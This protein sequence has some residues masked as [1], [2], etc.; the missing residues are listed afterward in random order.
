MRTARTLSRG[1]AVALLA[2]LAACSSSDSD[3]T[4]AY[5][6][7][8]TYGAEH[9][10]GGA[11]GTWYSDQDVVITEAGEVF[12][13]TVAIVNP[14]FGTNALSW[15]TADGNATNADLAFADASTSA[16]YWGAGGHT[17][18]LFEGRI[19]YPGEG[20]L[21]Y[22]GVLREPG[23]TASGVLGG[24][25]F[26]PAD[27]VAQVW[28][29]QACGAYGITAIELLFLS[30]PGSCAWLQTMRS[31]DEKAN[32]VAVAAIVGRITDVSG[33][34]P[35]DITP[36]VYPLSYS[37]TAAQWAYVRTNA[38]CVD[39]AEDVTPTGGALTIAS[40]SA[41]YV[42]G[43]IA[44][45][46]SDGSTFGGTFSAPTCPSYDLCADCTAPVCVP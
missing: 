7:A 42:T 43:S 4:P 2:V 5:P 40:V 31:C 24:V 37:G 16:Y 1:A 21:D 46:F 39:A 25:S 19:Q 9:R 41:G 14:T 23:S 45:T 27:V 30:T 3:T 6:W 36:G 12:R 11:S 35:A 22:R 15:A 26:S 28:T 20:Y 32:L 33:G 18:R 10:W 13:G 44:A 29:P 38:S 17:G 34:L 8:G